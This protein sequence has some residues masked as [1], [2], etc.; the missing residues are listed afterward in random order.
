[1]ASMY[2]VRSIWSGFSGAPGYTN[3]YFGTTDPL[4][5]GATQACTDVRAFWQAC[6][7]V[8]PDDVQINVEPNVQ[9]V[10]DSTGLVED[11]LS[12]TATAAVNGTSGAAYAAP[13]GASIEWRTSQFVNGR[14]VKGRSY[15]VPLVST[16][17]ETD[18]TLI[19][20]ALTA[21][22]AAA[23]GLIAAPSQFVVWHRPV[24]ASAG[25]PPVEASAGSLHLV[26][27]AGVSDR[28]AVLRSRRD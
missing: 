14:R 17:Y 22:Q 2:R 12:T 3:M 24:E 4:L 27:T 1:M 23:A 18:G 26:A 20:A 7:S 11:E 21:L 5:A 8:F 6:V 10:E 9:I 13:C 28:V 25:P 15:L 19:A 16:S